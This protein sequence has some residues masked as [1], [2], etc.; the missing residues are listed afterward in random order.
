MLFDYNHGRNYKENVYH[1]DY[2]NF[3]VNKA[4]KKPKHK[5]TFKPVRLQYPD[6]E[7]TPHA[8]PPPMSY[9]KPQEAYLAFTF[10][11]QPTKTM[12]G[13]LPLYHQPHGYFYRI[14]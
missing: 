1:N 6:H 12:K 4:N 11:S 10:P 9:N 5:A 2:N 13:F 14:L 7:N 8:I 3:E